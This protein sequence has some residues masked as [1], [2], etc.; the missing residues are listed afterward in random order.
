MAFG[1]GL[2]A[3]DAIVNAESAGEAA[4]AA[5]GTCGN[6][7]TALSFLGWASYPVG[8]LN[9]D[10][11]SNLLQ[12]DLSRWDVALDFATEAPSTA[13]PIILHTIR[14]DA[15]G[16]PTHSFSF[17]CP[18]CGSWFPRFRPVRQEAAH[19]VLERLRA[20]DP[21]DAPEV[22]FFDR[23]S[24]ASLVLAEEFAA[25]GS[26]VMFEPSG[27]GKASLFEEA[28]ELAHI[29]KY[30]RQRMGRL[31]TRP[32][33]AGNC[34]LEIETLGGEGLRYR[35]SRTSWSWVPKK[36]LRGPTPMDY[37]GAGDWC[38]AAVL[39]DVAVG[40]LDQ[41]ASRTRDDLEA[42]LH[43]GQAAAAVACG[44]EGARGVMYA[45]EAEEFRK[46]SENLASSSLEPHPPLL[47]ETGAS[48]PG[49]H[50]VA[51][52]DVCPSCHRSLEDRQSSRP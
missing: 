28:L 30:S 27:I 26:V 34:L 25:L 19:S 23:V 35:A 51:L 2:I 21:V 11:A 22:F 31:A 16:V 4:L 38:T 48:H 10:A 13:T 40:G 9:G 29:L 37:A 24:R 32:P 18:E 14:R 15:D 45:L 43:G 12:Q 36:A 5:G 20:G 49:L 39:A 17:V 52:V 3:L 42:A 46:A 44:F 41:L 6:V 1:T 8:R 33:H 50:S 7:L 47:C